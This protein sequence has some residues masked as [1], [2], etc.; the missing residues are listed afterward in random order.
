MAFCGKIPKDARSVEGAARA[1]FAAPN[2]LVKVRSFIGNL[3]VESAWYR[4]HDYS[5][6]IF[7]DDQEKP[8]EGLYVELARMIQVEPASMILITSLLCV[9]PLCFGLRLS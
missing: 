2:K 8:K 4:I 7:D 6:K 5:D 9:R 1:S 3:E